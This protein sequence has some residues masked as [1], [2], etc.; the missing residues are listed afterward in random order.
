MSPSIT[1]QWYSGMN[2]HLERINDAIQFQ[3]RNERG[4]RVTVAG[5]AEQDGVSPMEMVAIGFGGCSSI[6]ILSILEKQR[7][8]V[9]D[10]DVEVDA[11][12]ADDTPAVFTELHA[13]YR[14]EGDVEPDKVQRAIELS[15][16]T[17]CSVSKML[18]KAVTISYTFSVNDETYE[19]AT[20]QIA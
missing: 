8:P 7:Q 4:H 14:V 12:R 16:D 5:S 1:H 17:Y 20:R 13:H 18:E 15:L 9:E 11:E 6:D 10:F 2:V 3:A 19:G